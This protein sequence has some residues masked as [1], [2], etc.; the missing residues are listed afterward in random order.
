MKGNF[1]NSKQFG[2]EIIFRN[3]LTYTVTMGKKLN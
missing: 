3:L 1:L 2:M